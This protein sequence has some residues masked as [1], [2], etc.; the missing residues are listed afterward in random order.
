MT[1]NP[2]KTSDLSYKPRADQTCSGCGQPATSCRCISNIKW[3]P[4]VKAQDKVER[5]FDRWL[6]KEGWPVGY[7][8]GALYTQMLKAFRGGYAQRDRVQS[9]KARAR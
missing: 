1:K 5:A 7:P 8:T 2:D 3:P 9:G 6:R 4:S